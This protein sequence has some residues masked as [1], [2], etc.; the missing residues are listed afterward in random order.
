MV[1]IDA[2]HPRGPFPD[3]LMLANGVRW[4]WVNTGWTSVNVCPGCLQ[5]RS[6]V[7]GGHP[8]G[9]SGPRGMCLRCGLKFLDD[10]LI[11]GVVARF[12][13]DPGQWWPWWTGRGKWEVSRQ[14]A[15]LILEHNESDNPPRFG[16]PVGSGSLVKGRK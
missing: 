16:L 2:L 9:V 15:P 8:K 4:T 1:Q 12:V 11:T 14:T 6:V 7:V 5:V 3:K 10:P 13:N